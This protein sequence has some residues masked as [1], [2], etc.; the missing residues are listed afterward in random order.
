MGC[1]PH[2]YFAGGI[3]YRVPALAATL[4]PLGEDILGGLQHSST[5]EKVEKNRAATVQQN[6]HSSISRSLER[7][8]LEEKYRPVRSVTL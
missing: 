1:S 7:E 2:S 3:A 8:K 5:K 6:L 4:S